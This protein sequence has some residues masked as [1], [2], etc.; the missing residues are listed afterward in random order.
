MLV[1]GTYPVQVLH[2]QKRQWLIVAIA[3]ICGILGALFGKGY[4]PLFSTLAMLTGGL[5]VWA[6]AK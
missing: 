4:G 5:L 3:V 2:L 1:A 6:D